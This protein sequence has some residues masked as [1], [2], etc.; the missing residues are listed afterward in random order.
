MIW[1]SI[2]KIINRLGY[3]IERKRSREEVWANH[4]SYGVNENLELFFNSKIYIESLALRFNKFKLRSHENGFIVSFFNL[5]IFVESTEEFF[6]L[7]EVFIRN[8]YKFKSSNEAVVIDI[9]ANIGISSLYFSTLDNVK[10]I[11]SF[12]PVLDSF[13]QATY[14]LELNNNIS[15]V[16]T[17]K[18]IGLGK[19]VREETFI[20]N[21]KTKG[22]TGVR[23][24]LSSTMSVNPDNENRLVYIKNASIELKPILKTHP[25]NAIVIKMDCEGGEYE[26]MNDLD[27]SGLLK[28]IDI[29]MLEWH[30]RGASEIEEILIKNN[31][32]IFSRTL[33]D[34]AGLIHACKSR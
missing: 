31:F 28:D 2:Y 19:E 33:S 25:N 20:Y 13:K 3:R 11:Y 21:K 23:G 5:N 7:E 6:I 16:A 24:L 10:S 29:M 15:K 12:E 17:I 14:N 32:T 34:N 27:N 22:N 8:D 26:I 4:E 9:G 30:D 1:K 18:N